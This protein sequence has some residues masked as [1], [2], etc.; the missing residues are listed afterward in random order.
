M[1]VSVLGLEDRIGNFVV[2]KEFDALLV[3]PKAAGSP[4]DVF[5]SSFSDSLEVSYKCTTCI[6]NS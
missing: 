6:K 2:G 4:F 5:N 3:N 1:T